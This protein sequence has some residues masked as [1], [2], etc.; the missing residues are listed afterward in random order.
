[1]LDIYDDRK[2]GTLV[3]WLCEAEHTNTGDKLVIYCYQNDPADV[4]AIDASDFHRQYQ[5][6]SQRRGL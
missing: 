5:L 1:M 2:T 4:R 3:R 6:K